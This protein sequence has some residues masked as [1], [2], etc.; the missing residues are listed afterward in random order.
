MHK[1]VLVDMCGVAEMVSVPG[2]C[3][4]DI[5]V[6]HG[7]ECEA[8]EVSVLSGPFCGDAPAIIKSD[9]FPYVLDVVC[10]VPDCLSDD[11]GSDY[12]DSHSTYRLSV[13]MIDHAVMR[14][15]SSESWV[16]GCVCEA[17]AL[18]P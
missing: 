9:N 5:V 18:N 16:L 13:V 1:T 2:R 12:A 10:V 15:A 8:G 7:N 6:T 17:G 3:Y 11:S 4:T 14:E